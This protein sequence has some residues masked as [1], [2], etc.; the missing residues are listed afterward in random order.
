MGESCMIREIK[1]EELDELLALYAQLHPDDGAAPR[2]RIVAVW[3]AM[4]SDPRQRVIVA[5][6]NGRIVA[7]CV[8]VLVPN[9]TRAA[10]GYALVENVVTDAAHRRQGWA[11]R[12]LDYA[13]ALAVREGCYKMM[14]MTSSKEEGT[15]RFYERAGY[16]RAD[17]TAFVQW[18]P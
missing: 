2:E 12:C 10:S 1:P 4:L 16:N 17:K 3:Q 11:T 6:A 14:L 9:L 15:L 13:K 8:L 5:E 7:S 18:L